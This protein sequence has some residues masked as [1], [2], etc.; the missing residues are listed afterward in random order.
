MHFFSNHL[1]CCCFVRDYFRNITLKL[2]IIIFV[3]LFFTNTS[4]GR[5]YTVYYIHLGSFENKTITLFTLPLINGIHGIR[6][7]TNFAYILTLTSVQCNMHG[8]K[9]I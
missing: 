6:K 1:F 5:T 9:Q 7:R 2:N 3:V 8:L 4:N